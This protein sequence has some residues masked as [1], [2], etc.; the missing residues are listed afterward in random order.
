MYNA[1]F[2]LLVSI[3]LGAICPNILKDIYKMKGKK[4]YILLTTLTSITYAFLIAKPII[5]LK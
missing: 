5:E 2:G 3:F 4:K 1:T